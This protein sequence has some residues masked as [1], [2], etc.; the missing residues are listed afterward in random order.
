MLK[1]DAQA[2]LERRDTE[3]TEITI[4]SA[5]VV[6][7][8]LQLKSREQMK[9]IF[10]EHIWTQPLIDMRFDYKPKNPLYLLLVRAYRLQ[11]SIKIA[12]TPEYAGCKSWVPIDRAIET[13]GHIV[14]LDDAGFAR[15][16]KSILDR[17]AAS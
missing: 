17:I 6:T 1:Q 5:G 11:R 2:T 3:P 12:N 13:T 8:I 7:D 10:D 16:R 9:A 15:R 4:A 14:A